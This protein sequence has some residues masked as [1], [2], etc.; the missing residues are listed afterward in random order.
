[1]SWIVRKNCLL[2]PFSGKQTIS[3][4]MNCY[5]MLGKSGAEAL[6]ERGESEGLVGLVAFYFKQLYSTELRSAH[7]F[8]GKT[9]TKGSTEAG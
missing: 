4:K 9:K 8:K 2:L 5:S 3:E 6:E 7:V 1:M